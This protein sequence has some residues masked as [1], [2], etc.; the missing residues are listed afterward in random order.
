M[1]PF[2]TSNGNHWDFYRLGKRK[3]INHEVISVQIDVENNPSQIKLKKLKRP[4]DLRTNPRYW[5]ICQET[6]EIIARKSIRDIVQSERQT[7][8]TTDLGS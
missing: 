3:P 7:D 5:A 6:G 1:K 2:E 4:V 8:A